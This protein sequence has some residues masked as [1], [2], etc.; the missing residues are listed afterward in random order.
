M[1]QLIVHLCLSA[2]LSYGIAIPIDSDNCLTIGAQK[3]CGSFKSC[4]FS[5]SPVS[6]WDV[7]LSKEVMDYTRASV[8]LSMMDYI[9]NIAVR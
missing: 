5:V 2:N 6:R 9:P 1:I 8:P 3:N 7:A 4:I